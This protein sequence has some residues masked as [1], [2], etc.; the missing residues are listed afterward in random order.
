MIRT[1]FLQ[2]TGLRYVNLLDMI[3]AHE[4]N[5]C[6]REKCGLLGCDC[7]KNI[8]RSN[9]YNRGKRKCLIQHMDQIDIMVKNVK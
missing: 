7:E 3:V 1:S 4:T 8:R 2:L 9:S 5:R 6:N